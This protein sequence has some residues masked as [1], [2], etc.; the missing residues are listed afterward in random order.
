[1]FSVNHS[2]FAWEQRDGRA[3]SHRRSASVSICQRNA[4]CRTRVSFSAIT[5]TAVMS[6][7]AGRCRLNIRRDRSDASV[8]LQTRLCRTERACF[9]H[10][11]PG[12]IRAAVLPCEAAPP[13]F[14]RELL[15]LV[16]LHKRNAR[17]PSHAD[18]SSIPTRALNSRIH[19][20]GASAR[21]RAMPRRRT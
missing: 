10:V 14:R 19:H 3:R 4:D 13:N 18:I 2:A 7:A 17:T 20:D 9:F 5:T 1:M 6:F 15:L 11:P 8:I 12:I 16:S 21:A